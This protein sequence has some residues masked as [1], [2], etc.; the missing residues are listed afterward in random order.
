VRPIVSAQAWH[1]LDPETRYL[2][3]SAALRVGGTLAAIWTFPD[4]DRI[5]LRDG[6]REVYLRSVPALAPDFPMHPASEPTDL[7]GDWRAEIDGA[8]ELGQ[9]EVRLERWPI[10]YTSEEYRALLQ[11]HQDHI[12]LD[13]ATCE[14]LLARVVQAIDGAGGT[15]TMRFV[16]RLC[17]ARRI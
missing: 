16:T 11:T 1:W 7:A 14:T 8:A 12:L 17:L 10:T 15:I 6:L 4:W 13:P 9:P 5:P 3:A 2:R